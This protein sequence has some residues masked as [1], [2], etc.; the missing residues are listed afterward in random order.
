MAKPDTKPT[1]FKG[2]KFEG[3]GFQKQDGSKFQKGFQKKDGAK[4]WPKEGGGGGKPWKE[5]GGK[6]FQKDG[7]KGFQKKFEGGGKNF[8]QKKEGFE[9]R[10]EGGETMKKKAILDDDEEEELELKINE[11]F[12]KQYEEKK[13]SQ[14]LSQCMSPLLQF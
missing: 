9:E 10:Q 4:P 11:K 1:N 5:G 2:K 12:A 14:E 13:K 3:N 6:N 7:G 8:N